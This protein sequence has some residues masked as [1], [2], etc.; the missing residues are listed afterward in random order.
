MSFNINAD[1]IQ[2][3]NELKNE[4]RKFIRQEVRRQI[5]LIIDE[6]IDKRIEKKVINDVL[7]T[8]VNTT[9]NK[10]NNASSRE[11]QIKNKIQDLEK[12]YANL[13]PF[14]KRER[15]RI[16]NK[17]DYIK[18]TNPGIFGQAY[19]N[20]PNAIIHLTPQTNKNM[21]KHSFRGSRRSEG[22]KLYIDKDK[23]DKWK[24]KKKAG[25]FGKI[26]R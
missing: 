4:L 7:T 12:Q 26:I 18:E 15:E 21:G 16:Q 1:N 5:S 23:F 19:S 11:K 20:K 22:E 14:K 10:N 9:A 25:G 17:I 13:P 8:D 2:L 6:K 24:L 3:K